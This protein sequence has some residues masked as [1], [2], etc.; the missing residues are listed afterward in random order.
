MLTN[1]PKIV[2]YRAFGREVP[3]IVL[4]ARS[5]EVSHLGASGEPLLTLAFIDPAREV[6][7]APKKNTHVLLPETSTPQIHIEH[8]VVHASHEFDDEFKKKHGS[9]PAQIASQRGHGEWT[10][11]VGDATELIHALRTDRKTALD[12]FR[13]ATQEANTQRARAD[14]AESVSESLRKEIE[15]LRGPGQTV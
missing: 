7:V 2:L 14:L 6:A 15:A 10:E 5:G 3:A 9:S 11:Y 8:D 13:L 1:T 4:N 12:N